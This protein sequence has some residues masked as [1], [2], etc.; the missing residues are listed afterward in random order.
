MITSEEMDKQQRAVQ[1]LFPDSGLLRRVERMSI[2]SKGR[3]RGTLQGKRRSQTLGSSLEFAD[4][5]PYSP[6]DD[7]RR[8]D[9]NVYGRTGKAFVRQYWDEQEITV[10]LYIDIS[11]SMH[12][13]ADGDWGDTQ[14]S[15]KLAD[16][17]ASIPAT[18]KLAY[19][20]RLAA[21]IGYAALS[22]EDRVAA[23]RF[24]SGITGSLQP[25]RGRASAARLFTFLAESW[26]PHTDKGSEDMS[27]SF[28]VLGSLPRQSGQAWLFSDGLYESG[29]EAT[30]DALL[31]AGQEVVF[32]HLLGPEEL[33][34]TLSGE[35]KLID[36]ESGYGKEV[37]I[38]GNVL[39]AYQK[40]VHEHSD[41][42]RRICVQ[43]G[44]VYLFVD[45]S[46]SLEDTAIQTMLAHGLLK[47]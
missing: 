42:I 27:A 13:M 6:G 41:Y 45:T 29:I 21:C 5:R 28:T 1:W 14:L 7:I 9:W 10:R 35:L 40:A 36:A 18:N 30:L 31:S 22:G 39:T 20:L 3:V 34:P 43:R 32:V 8:L 2:A 46:D 33:Q 12:F 44:C 11:L 19:A 26:N 4:Y 37:A 17:G 15:S 24:A 23:Y 47:G 16:T 38:G 25:V